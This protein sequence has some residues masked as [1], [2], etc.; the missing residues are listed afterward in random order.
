MLLAM[1]YILLGLYIG[2]PP[3]TVLVLVRVARRTKSYLP[4]LSFIVSGAAALVLASF[5]VVLN[6]AA[7]GGRADLPEFGRIAWLVL[8]ALCF[9][10]WVDWG[11]SRLICRLFAR[12]DKTSGQGGWV[13]GLLLVQRGMVILAGLIWLSAMFLVV[14]PK[15]DHTGEGN[16]FTRLGLPFEQIELAAS[17][18]VALAGWWIPAATPSDRTVILV[19]GVGLGRHSF[20]GTV[21]PGTRMPRER[22]LIE[23]LHHAGCNVLVFDPRGQGDSGGWVSSAGGL[24]NYDVIG[25]VRWVREHRPAQSKALYALGINS[26]AAAVVMATANGG[27]EAQA[28]RGIVLYEPFA[29]LDGVIR[30]NAQRLPRPLQPLW[31][32][33]VAPIASAHAGS[34]LAGFT[35]ADAAGR[36]WG[37]R[38]LVIHGRDQTFVPIGQEMSFYQ[39]VSCL[40]AQFW[41]SDNYLARRA[42]VER[43]ASMK[44]LNAVLEESSMQLRDL[45][46]SGEGGML[47]DYGAQEQVLRF[48][49]VLDDQDTPAYV[50]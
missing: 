34:N 40:K 3:V 26:G 39:S 37:K 10:R 27:D 49:R 16:P 8:A 9:I 23:A 36:L 11:L 13:R 28:I 12:G 22:G 43:L 30:S 47:N 45:S 6:Q 31:G 46:G 18:G 19:P 4:L 21:D 1:H 5:V 41:P 50:L 17:D 7:F 42:Q 20:L 44:P 2:L 14:R 24:E 33:L 32:H 38:C 29:S 15:L 35:P 25:A 48:L